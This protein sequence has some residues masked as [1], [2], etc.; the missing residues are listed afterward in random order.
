MWPPDVPCAPCL[1]RPLLLC[2]VACGIL[3]AR[4]RQFYKGRKKGD[5]GGVG[6]SAPS[7]DYSRAAEN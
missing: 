6:I 2:A 4:G 5:G 7:R 1:G 3:G